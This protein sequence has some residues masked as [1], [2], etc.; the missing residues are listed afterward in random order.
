M[1]EFRRGTKLLL[2]IALCVLMI[3]SMLVLVPHEV[4]AAPQDG[5]IEGTVSDGAIPIPN[6]LLIYILNMGGGGNPLGSGLTDALGHYNLTVAGDLSY[7]VL[8]FEGDYFSNASTVSVVSGATA[9]A[10]INLAPIAPTFVADVTLRGFVK[11]ETGDP[12]TEGTIMGFTN[13]P[14][15]TDGGPPYYGN[16]T[17]PDTLGA[18]SVNVI[19]GTAGGGVGIMGV[20]GY[21]FVDRSTSN[22]FVSGTTYWLNITLAPSIS[23]DDA[24]I[25]GNV[26]D[27]KTGLDL[28]SVLVNF[29]SS[30]DWNKNRSYSNYTFTDPQGHYKMNV[31]NGTSNIMFS[32]AG[33]G[34]YRLSEMSV[35]H[36]ANLRINA[37]LLPLTATV[38]GNVTDASLAPIANAQVLVFDQTRNNIS[39]AVTNSLGKFAFDVFDGTNLSFGAQA[40]GYG[41]DW[42]VIDILPGDSISQDFVLTSFDAWMTGKVTNELNGFPI[43]NA[44]VQAHSTIFNASGP[45]NSMGDYNVSLVSGTTYTVNVDAMGY[46]HYSSEVAVAPGENVYNVE[47][48]PLDAWMTG[49]VTDKLSG[50]PIENAGVWVHSS[51]FENWNATDS[52]GDYNVTLASGTTYTVDVD[53]M[54]Y[55][56]N[57]SELAVVSGEN[58]YDVQLLPNVLPETTKLYGW[59]ND[60]SSLSGIANAQ[61]QVG[62]PPPDYGG[63]NQT[64]TSGT[65]YYEMWV[66]PV[67]LMCVVTA[68]DHV[69]AQDTINAIG[70]AM[71]RHDVLLDLDI[72]NPNVTSYDQSPSLNISWTNPSLVHAVV[73]EQDP[74]QFV[75]AYAIYNHTIGIHAYFYIVQMLYDSFNPFNYA[76]NN[77]PYSQAGDVYTIDYNWIG[78]AH[79]GLLTN[80]TDN[81]YLGSYERMKDSQVFNAIGGYYINSTLGSWMSG[82]ALFDQST[83]DFAWF[84]FDGSMP[85]A[86]PSDSTG[87]FQPSVTM[88]E[89]DETNGNPNWYMDWRLGDWSVAGLKFAYNELLPSGRYVSQFFVSDFGQRGWGQL[90]NLTVDNDIPVASAGDDQ[91]VAGGEE[92]FFDGT[93][94]S[95]S[96][97]I[98]NWTWSFTY[99]GTYYEVWGEHASFTFS[100]GDELVTVTLTVTDGA[101]HTSSDTMLVNV[102]NVIPE[103]PTMLLPVMGILALFALVSVR[104]RFEKG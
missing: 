75:L 93:L 52:A 64:M 87:V 18:Y 60:S 79:G 76:S 82:S 71:L 67:E 88:I 38:S 42:T 95:D 30:N 90:T 7:M 1:S 40:N 34:I 104:R 11:N 19:A 12:V 51:V 49:K 29:D 36:G 85:W 4:G 22:E 8:A 2:A 17:T 98:A 69:H 37:S 70:K 55:R 99:G 100:G 14:S 45:T 72:W 61:V 24:V 91:V 9:F 65:G 6:V 54:G 77:L 57:T 102:G 84:Q 53:A 35:N 103:F 83:G 16:S 21:G 62:L 47:L 48:L 50:S 20:P 31:T 78:T 27:S 56:H 92:V 39:Y 26:T 23:T 89:I 81:Q 32:K 43:E 46:G 58:L 10:D 86:D 25:R 41:P 44:N 13:N 101:G 5:W 28:G 73:Q 59:I 15:M 97:G 63:Q 68:S 80:M 74:S 66:S 96:S 33:Y 94:S 3:T